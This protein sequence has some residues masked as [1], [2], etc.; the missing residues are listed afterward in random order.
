MQQAAN[1]AI[2]DEPVI[3]RSPINL[4]QLFRQSTVVTVLAQVKHLSVG[5]GGSILCTLEL[6]IGS[7]VANT[8]R[9]L[10]P[11]LRLKNE[12]VIAKLLHTSSGKFTLLS[13]RETSMRKNG[14]TTAWL[15][16]TESHRTAHIKRLRL[17]LSTMEPALQAIFMG[18]MA[19]EAFEKTWLTRISATDHHTYPTG[20]FDHSVE[21]AEWMFKCSYLTPREQGVTALACLL[22]DIGKV[23]DEQYR[24]DAMRLRQGLAPHPSTAQLLS[25][26][27]AC[28]A[29]HDKELVDLLKTVMGKL[30]WTEWI[31]P[32]G[33][34]WT[35]KQHM[36]DTVQW[37]WGLPVVGNVNHC[38]KGERT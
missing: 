34:E 26:T 33:I 4:H 18:V 30:D 6:S 17:L 37:S 9:E 13:A 35:M 2:T 14:P 15:P 27:L 32:P 24:P 21:G 11:I 28:V 10:V 8:K 31:S 23:K 16:R 29:Q 3:A 20:L 22:F 38:G 36:H 7:I 25:P 12:W 19:T 5:L 1:T